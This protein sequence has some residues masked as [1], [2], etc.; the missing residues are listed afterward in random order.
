MAEQMDNDDLEVLNISDD[1]DQGDAGA[2][3]VV[4]AARVSACRMRRS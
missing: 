1:G 3:G 2:G 4:S